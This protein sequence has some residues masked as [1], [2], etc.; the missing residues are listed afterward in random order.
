MSHGLLPY[1]VEV[2]PDAAGLTSRAGLPLVLETMRALGLPRVIREHVHIRARQSGYTEGEKIEA[3]VLLLAAGGDCLDDIAV[4]Q[5]DSGLGRLVER[6]LPS[7]DTLRHFLYACHDDQVIATAQ[8]QRPI[9]QT[10]YI[11]AENAVLQGLARVN[12]ALVHRVAAQGKSTTATLDHDATI[13]ESHKRE[14]RPHYK[15]GRGY[16]PTAVYWVEQDLVVADEYR[17]GNVGAGMETL[18]LI[19]RAFAS[20]PA[21]VNTFCFRADTACYNEPTLKWL[22]DPARPGGPV[23]PIGFTIGAD[24]TKDLHAV[25]AAVP[26]ARWALFEDRPDET[27]HCTDV[28]FTPG[29]WKKDAQ[30]LRYLALRIRK[31]Q[32]QLFAS[33]ADTKYLAVVSN[34]WEL[35]PAALLRWHWQK[36]GTIELVHDITKNELGAAV[37][38]CGRFGANAAWYRLSLLT[39]NVLS[40]LK[41]LALPPSLS[42]AR[43]KRLRFT[44]FTLAGRLV[45]HARQLVLRVSAA[46]ERLAGLI[47]ARRRLALVAQA[48]P[49]G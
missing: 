39:Y 9:G 11:P 18:P 27:V 26:A 14:A 12:M 37:P 3:L 45:T 47:A 33:G 31:K 22:A 40:A 17:D 25:C 21:S 34:R 16:Q 41:S 15:G 30:P 36:A 10:A 7:A 35:A 19:Q 48:L 23:G 28:E 1:T 20:L 4:L 29:T 13:Q 24:M 38:P 43:P 49:A 8:A 44:L 6:Q 32:G 2:V 42:T 46:A 5:A